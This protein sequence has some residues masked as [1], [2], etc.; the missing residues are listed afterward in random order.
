MNTKRNK[1]KNGNNTGFSGTTTLFALVLIL[2]VGIGIVFANGPV[3][4]RESG[5][6]ATDDV[7]VAAKPAFADLDDDGD[8]DMMV[9]DSNGS[10]RAYNNTGSTSSPTWTYKPSWNGPNVGN[11]SKP[12]FAD[13]DDDGDYD[14]MVGEKEGVCFAY[15]NT[16]NASSPAWTYKPSWNAPDVGMGSKPTFADLDNDGDYD[17]LIGEGPN[18]IKYAFNNTGSASSP[19]WTYKPSWNPPNVQRGA[20]PV[21]E[22]LDDDDDYD[23]LIGEG[24]TGNT[25][26]YN[27]TGTIY[28]PTWT[29]QSSWDPPTVYL[30]AGPALADLDGDGDCDL[31]IGN[32]SGVSYAYNNTG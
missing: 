1:N 22:K 17:M 11:G 26:A 8:Y 6:D 21:L 12:A 32:F 27:N 23:L 14:M 18:G 15:N 24:P 16:G 13:L 29:R 2:S 10:L 5:W 7:G 30:A 25:L 9:G 28:S 4:T 3:W 19:T 31:L 20:S